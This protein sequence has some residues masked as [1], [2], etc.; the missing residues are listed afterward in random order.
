MWIKI[1]S[2]ILR[3]RLY[4]AS[5]LLVLTVLM[6][7]FATKTEMAYEL[8]NVIPEDDPTNI[9]YQQ[10]KQTFGEDG[11]MVVVGVATDKLFQLEF[12]QDWYRF[13]KDIEGLQ[14]VA[15][16]ISLPKLYNL[17]RNDSL[18]K[19][20]VKPL[21]ENEPQTQAEVDAIEA[22]IQNLPFYHNYLFNPETNATMI[23]I[24]FDS[25]ATQ[26]KRRESLVAELQALG[27][28]L[29][30]KHNVELSYSGVP[31]IRT[32]NSQKI[33]KEL[34][35]FTF[36]SI[37][38]TG[39]FILIFFRSL[40]IVASSLI[41]VAICL[42]YTIGSMYL[43]GFKIGILTALIPPLI[44]V[45]SI[46]N[47]VYLLNVYHFEYRTHKNKMLAL[48][49][50]ISKIGVA[51][52]LT[53]LT[54]AIGFGVF[55][56]TGSSLLD[57]FGRLAA[58]NIMVVYVLSVLLIP[59]LFSFLPG[60]SN[61]QLRHLDRK[62][63]SGVLSFVNRIV[64]N[65]R[66][67]VY[68]AAI[69]LVAVS[70]IGLSK[71]HTFGYI[72]DGISPKEKLY[73]DLKFFEQNFGGLFPFEVYID[74]KEEG[75]VRDLG[76]LQRL[77]LLSRKM[78][79]Y[80]ELSRP[81]SVSELM[82][83]INQAYYRG[84]PKRYILPNPL[85]MGKILNMMPNQYNKK[86]SDLLKSLIDTTYRYTRISCQIADVG[87]T[88][89]EEIRQSLRAQIDSV[90]PPE[91]FNVE[92]T[93]KSVVHVKGNSY[94]IKN[95]SVSLGWAFM[96]I[97]IIMALL[98]SSYKMIG[99]ALLP[100]LLPLF[101][102]LGIMGFS[103]ISLKESTILIFGVAFGIVVDLTIH[104][105]AKYR[106]ELKKYDYN[107]SQAVRASID[108]SGFSMIYTTVILFFGF[109][110]FAFSSFGGTVYLGLL[111][112]LSLAFGLFSNLFLL[113][114]LLLGMEKRMNMRESMKSSV[115]ELEEEDI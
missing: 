87:T 115:I 38:I 45:I 33:S 30:K 32:I 84:N 62:T 103:G 19:F 83:F 41:M 64:F 55:S 85:E 42:T 109:I 67:W 66:K 54:T 50:T 94:L 65:H 4:I 43:M 69:V 106:F 35:L 100:N 89:N 105:L 37:V 107:I 78:E 17:E 96:I 27:D 70:S 88:R 24:T 51:S 31:Y 68:S 18:W 47:S 113:P 81:M 26:T 2:F 25:T 80:P 49:R 91:E 6:G 95:L 99:I 52:L 48:T 71:V 11:S 5:V 39:I 102:T 76:V 59:I 10:F 79:E 20:Q 60:P 101:M 9:T 93:G 73:K 13:S 16:I 29:S 77:E 15:N 58:V 72:L 23:A 12:F 86:N 46:Q 36:L 14:N 111:T 61:K 22:A 7:Y 90:F 28:E 34:L 112:S 63:L 1:A 40:Q 3:F 82:K 108:H 110:I 74:T 75:M 56:F 57:E 8:V 114:S 53:N 44:V 104:Y 21:V 92:I 98:F 97:G